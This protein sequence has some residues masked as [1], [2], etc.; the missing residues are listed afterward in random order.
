MWSGQQI[1]RMIGGSEGMKN[2]II[3]KDGG[4]FDIATGFSEKLIESHGF[5]YNL[6]LQETADLDALRD[7]APNLALN[8]RNATAPSW[9][10]WCWAAFGILLQALALA[11]PSVTTY[12]WKWD[13]AGGAVPDYGY[14]CFFLGTVAV[15]AGMMACGH[16]IEG[17]TTEHEFV[18]TKEGKDRGLR[19]VK[20]QKACTVSDQH[21]SSY[22]LFNEKDNQSIRTSRLNTKDYR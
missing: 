17:I 12:Y 15:V 11:F 7:A 2:L 14:P 20:I 9:E 21:F 8:V 22:A 4:V 16:V 3:T 18:A 13:K 10:L 1:V 5:R 19:I 6:S